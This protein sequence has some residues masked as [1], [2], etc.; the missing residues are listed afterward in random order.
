M[1]YKFEAELTISVNLPDVDFHFL[2]RKAAHHYDSAVRGLTEQ[3]GVLYGSK[4]RR[5]YFDSDFAH[6]DT[7][8]TR[9]VI[10][11]NSRKLGYILKSLEM[12]VYSDKEQAY[13]LYKVLYDI[14]KHLSKNSMEINKKLDIEYDD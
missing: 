6:K 13:R 8:N 10:S 2:F 11:L 3:G 1:K 7:D 4:T 5:E 12:N 9:D 14:A